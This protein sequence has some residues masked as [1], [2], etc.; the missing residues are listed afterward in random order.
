MQGRD[1]TQV[2]RLGKQCKKPQRAIYSDTGKS[3]LVFH[4]DMEN[5]DPQ[6]VL[7]RTIV[8]KTFLPP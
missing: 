2:V 6:Q 5:P 4:P 1:D 7:Y 3:T 8:L